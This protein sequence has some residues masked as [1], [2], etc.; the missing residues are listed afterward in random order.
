MY[1]IDEKSVKNWDIQRKM[2][3]KEK[4]VF[5]MKRE[6]KLNIVCDNL[7]DTYIIYTFNRYNC[8]YTIFLL[9]KKV[10]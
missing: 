9:W 8:I 5:S 10:N 4:E 7:F 6:R 1:W 3:N 2:A